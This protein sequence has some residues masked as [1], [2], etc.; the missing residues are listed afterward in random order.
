MSPS[1]H[2]ATIHGMPIQ[3]LQRQG[4]RIIGY[5]QDRRRRLRDTQAQV[6]AIISARTRDHRDALVHLERGLAPDLRELYRSLRDPTATPVDVR[7]ALASLA[8]TATMLAENADCPLH[9]IVDVE[10]P[11]NYEPGDADT[12]HMDVRVVEHADEYGI[13][14]TTY[15]EDGTTLIRLVPSVRTDRALVTEA[16]RERITPNVPSLKAA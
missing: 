7:A 2:D 10:R 5:S 13:R 16:A 3:H 4:R 6:H 9:E 12:E 15:C 8:A 1:G 14:C 11:A